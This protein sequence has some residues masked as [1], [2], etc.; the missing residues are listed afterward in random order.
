MQDGTHEDISADGAQSSAGELPEEGEA[1][2]QRL[3][4]LGFPRAGAVEAYLACDQDEMLAANFLMD[5]Q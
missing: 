4:A 1:A 5:H 2:V 3:M